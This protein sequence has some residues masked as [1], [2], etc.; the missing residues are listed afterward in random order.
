[1]TFVLS[2]E[3]A[4]TEASERACEHASLILVFSP[5]AR[6][7]PMFFL[8]RLRSLSLAVRPSVRPSIRRVR[9]RLSVCPPLS[10]QTALVRQK[11]RHS[12][13]RRRRLHNM[14]IRRVRP[15]HRTAR[16][17][18]YYDLG[19]DLLIRVPGGGGATWWA[20]GAEQLWRISCTRPLG[21]VNLMLPNW[22]RL[23]H[24]QF[25]DGLQLLQPCCLTMTFL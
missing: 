16:L 21:R 4:K 24:T 13:E 8:L 11:L 7:S 5:T 1:M 25:L 10:M 20:L 3:D 6:G 18:A 9:P 2:L 22:A 17:P 23:P 12:A 15:L 14:S 19:G